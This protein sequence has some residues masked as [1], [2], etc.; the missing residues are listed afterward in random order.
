MK[1]KLTISSTLLLALF[2]ALAGCGKISDLHELYPALVAE[3][4]RR[5]FVLVYFR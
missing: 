5:A 4:E 1:R 2:L 3:Y